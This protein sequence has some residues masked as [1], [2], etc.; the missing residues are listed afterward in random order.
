MY[1]KSTC[2]DHILQDILCWS[3]VLF[4]KRSSDHLFPPGH[5]P[6]IV[7]ACAVSSAQLVI[8]CTSNIV[9]EGREVHSTCCKH[10]CRSC[11]LTSEAFIICLP[12]F[13]LCHI[14]KQASSSRRHSL[15]PPISLHILYMHKH[16]ATYRT[17][18]LHDTLHKADYISTTNKPTTQA[19][20]PK[21]PMIYLSLRTVRLMRSR[22]TSNSN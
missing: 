21:C 12:A 10:S 2:S 6:A 8:P 13:C 7:V 9:A 11:I 3:S 15:S 4:I 20:Q 17:Y 19:E 14:H 18:M 22:I 5:L 1:I 16:H